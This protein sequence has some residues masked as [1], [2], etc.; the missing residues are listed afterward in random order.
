VPILSTY[1]GV[2]PFVLADVL[3]LGLVVAFPALAL[4]L[5]NLLT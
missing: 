1:R 5:V 3:R 2:L 4:W